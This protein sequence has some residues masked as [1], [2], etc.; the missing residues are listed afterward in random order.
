MKLRSLRTTNTF[1]G[2]NGMSYQEAN[3]IAT[4]D[5]GSLRVVLKSVLPTRL[6]DRNGRSVS[7]I[8]CSFEFV[9]RETQRPIVV[10]L[11]AIPRNGRRGEGGENIIFIGNRVV[12]NEGT[13]IGS[14]LRTTL[15][16]ERG[17]AWSLSTSGVTGMSIVS[18]GKRSP[19]DVFSPTDIVSVLQRQDEIGTNMT[20]D[21][22]NPQLGAFAF[23]FGSTTPIES[24]QSASITMTFIPDAGEPTAG[25]PPKFFQ[26]NSEIVVGVTTGG[27]RSYSLYNLAFDRVNM[28]VY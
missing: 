19:F 27:K 2:A 12:T 6:N 4:K 8:R 18:V 20:R 7:G 24:G 22:D 17:T 15:L 9:S 11:N 10:A 3:A 25:A 14:V 1:G 13:S 23:V 28:P 26:I 16:D 5:I 21:A